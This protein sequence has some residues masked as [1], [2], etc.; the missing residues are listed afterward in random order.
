MM[1]VLQDH[2]ALRY[3]GSVDNLK[4]AGVQLPNDECEQ[5]LR[6]SFENN[7]ACPQRGAEIHRVER[8]RDRNCCYFS[9]CCSASRKRH[10]PSSVA[11][12]YTCCI[13]IKKCFTGSLRWNGPFKSCNVIFVCSDG[14]V[15]ISVRALWVEHCVFYVR[16]LLNWVP[17]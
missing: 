15:R 1:R 16:L 6:I 14:N 17:R 13:T 10:A 12:R 9:I 3:D 7:E 4:A 2:I 5:A 11:T 8:H